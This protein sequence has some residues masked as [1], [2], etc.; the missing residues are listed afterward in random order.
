VKRADVI[1]TLQSVVQHYVGS[2]LLRDAL[3]EAI[4]ALNVEQEEAEACEEA[5][6]ELGVDVAVVREA[7]T[8]IQAALVARMLRQEAPPAKM[9][10]A[11]TVGSLREWLSRFD[12]DLPVV[13]PDQRGELPAEYEPLRSVGLALYD[14]VTSQAVPLESNPPPETRGGSVLLLR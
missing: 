2:P 4:L 14:Q 6:A 8:K 10:N 5:A 13:V 1:A 7:R 9:P 11:W 12:A 3:S